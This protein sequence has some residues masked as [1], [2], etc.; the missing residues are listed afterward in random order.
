MISML[1]INLFDLSLPNKLEVTRNSVILK[2]FQLHSTEHPVIIV[3]SID[4]DDQSAGFSSRN[5]FTALFCGQYLSSN[6]SLPVLTV[7]DSVPCCQI[8]GGPPSQSGSQCGCCGESSS[9]T[10]SPLRIQKAPPV[11]S[12]CW[13]GPSL[14]SSSWHPTRPTW[15]PS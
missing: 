13:S 2:L 6:W 12:W 7:S 3:S 11:R 9:T 4:C 15:Q 8:P 5:C 10:P 14:P 1:N